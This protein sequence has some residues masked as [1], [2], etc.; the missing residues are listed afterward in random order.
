MVVK[1][2]F[3]VGCDYYNEGTSASLATCRLECRFKTIGRGRASHTNEATTGPDGNHI[4]P[5]ACQARGKHC[6]RLAWP[7]VPARPG[8]D[9][10]HWQCPVSAMSIANAV[11]SAGG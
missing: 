9:T 11:D 6:M 4:A 5:R 7:I 1:T 10:V 2:G 8:A 3:I